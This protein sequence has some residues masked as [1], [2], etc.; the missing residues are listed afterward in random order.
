VFSAE[1]TPVDERRDLS[2]VALDAEARLF[3]VQLTGEAALA[4][5]EVPPGLT[6]VYAS[7]QKGAYVDAVYP[8]GRGWISTMPQ[9]SFAVK[10]RYDVADMDAQRVG[11]SVQQLSAG[12]NFRPTQ[13]SVLKFD[14][15][16]GRRRD[17]FNNRSDHAFLL[18]SIATYF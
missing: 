9:S 15:V 2:I 5:V 18:F 14:Y 7:R 17:E 3:G 11:Q 16:R 6:G 8:F 1:G 10:V 13:D 4:R 12:L